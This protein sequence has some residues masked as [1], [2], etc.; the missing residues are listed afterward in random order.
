[1]RTLDGKVKM[2]VSR[3]T[4]LDVVKGHISKRE[5]DLNPAFE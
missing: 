4:F 2:G 3:E 5:L 1:V